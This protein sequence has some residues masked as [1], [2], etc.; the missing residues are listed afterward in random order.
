MTI[1]YVSVLSLWLVQVNKAHAV[2]LTLANVAFLVLHLC[3]PYTLLILQMIP[4]YFLLQ[5][6]H[7]YQ[8]TTINILQIQFYFGTIEINMI[9]S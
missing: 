4:F 5:N 2:V 7:I 9:L 1:L 6:L 3:L 8:S